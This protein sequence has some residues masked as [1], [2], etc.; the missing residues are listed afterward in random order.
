MTLIRGSG[1]DPR[2]MATFSINLWELRRGIASK[3]IDPRRVY[4]LAPP[5]PRR[6]LDRRI[7]GRN[8]RVIAP[9]NVGYRPVETRIKLA[10]TV[11]DCA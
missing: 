4:L 2:R 7:K 5:C 3:T 1:F 9:A 8:A 10:E 11:S 6:P